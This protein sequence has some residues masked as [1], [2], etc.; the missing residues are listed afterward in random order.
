M[1]TNMWGKDEKKEENNAKTQKQQSTKQNYHILSKCTSL[2]RLFLPKISGSSAFFKT[3]NNQKIYG[4]WLGNCLCLL[5]FLLFANY[6]Y[7]RKSLPNVTW[8]RVFS[9]TWSFVEIKFIFLSLLGTTNKVH[10][11]NIFAHSLRTLN[12]GT[13]SQSRMG[14]AA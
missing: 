14:Y 4:F 10:K 7:C 13:N 11:H 6:Y 1:W 2:K 3:K 8:A 9:F 12:I 5:V